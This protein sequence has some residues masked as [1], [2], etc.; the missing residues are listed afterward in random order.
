MKHFPGVHP[1]EFS[2]WL[3]RADKKGIAEE[4][5]SEG[6]AMTPWLHG[7]CVHA[8]TAMFANASRWTS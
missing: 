4:S 6:P 5:P 8:A 3:S 1:S 2:R 7:T